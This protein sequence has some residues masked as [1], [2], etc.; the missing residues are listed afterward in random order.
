MSQPVGRVREGAGRR[1]GAAAAFT[2]TQT[3]YST[4]CCATSSTKGREDGGGAAAIGQ[5]AG[6]TSPGLLKTINLQYGEVGD[7]PGR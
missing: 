5:L 1:A 3:T 6:L 4:F 7:L 2:P